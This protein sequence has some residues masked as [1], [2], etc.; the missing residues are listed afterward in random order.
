MNNISIKRKQQ[1]YSPS[2]ALPCTRL[3]YHC[4]GAN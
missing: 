1:Q 2:E 3:G 4:F